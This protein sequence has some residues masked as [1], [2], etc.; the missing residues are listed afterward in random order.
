MPSAGDELPPLFGHFAGSTPLSD[1]LPTFMSRLWLIT[2]LD[3]PAHSF[4]SG[5]GRVSRFS[6][7]EVPCMS[8][9]FDLACPVGARDVVSSSVYFPSNCQCWYLDFQIFRVSM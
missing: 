4:V 6:R 1:S 5:I 9:V 8:E 2:F 7:V 3:R